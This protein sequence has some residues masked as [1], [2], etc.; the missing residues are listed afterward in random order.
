MVQIKLEKVKPGMKQTQ[1]LV[2][3]LY[4]GEPEL[5]FKRLENNLSSVIKEIVENGEFTGT[6]G[7]NYLLPT[8]GKIRPKR[9]M[10]IGLG[11]KEKY[12]KTMQEYAGKISLEVQ[13]LGLREIQSCAVLVLD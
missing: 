5:L 12:S 9:I 6:F 2:L 11:K 4:E 10:L 1:L 8:F 7:S 13:E 3:G